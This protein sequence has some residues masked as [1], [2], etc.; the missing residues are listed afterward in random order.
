MVEWLGWQPDGASEEMGEVYRL[1]LVGCPA[2][3]VGEMEPDALPAEETAAKPGGR[4][5]RSFSKQKQ[6][7]MFGET[8]S[9]TS[10]GPFV[11]DRGL[12]ARHQVSL[13]HAACQG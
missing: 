6:Q 10:S 1:K 3:R 5:S 13:C 8:H 9:S 7:A 11:E 2:E 4:C 12:V